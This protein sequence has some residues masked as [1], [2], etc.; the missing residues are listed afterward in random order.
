MFVRPPRGGSGVT[1][2][3]C[4]EV[5]CLFVPLWTLDARGLAFPNVE[6]WSIPDVV[7]ALTRAAPRPRLARPWLLVTLDVANIGRVGI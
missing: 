4:A 6:R 2:E 7:R 1:A 5:V 3:S